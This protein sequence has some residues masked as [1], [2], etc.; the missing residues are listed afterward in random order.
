MFRML[1]SFN[2][3]Y[4]DRFHQAL[5]GILVICSRFDLISSIGRPTLPLT[6]R[7]DGYWYKNDVNNVSNVSNVE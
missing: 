3:F 2:M 7:G 1:M 5:S 4:V 6:A